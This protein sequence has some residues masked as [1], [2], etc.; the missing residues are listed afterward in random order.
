MKKQLVIIL[1]A[2]FAIGATNT[3]GQCPIPRPVDPVCLPSDAFH[4]VAGTPY[5]YTV[6]VPTPVGTKEYTWLVTQDQNFI[7]AGALVATPQAVPGPIVLAAGP[8]YNDP[9]T[10]SNTINITWNSFVYDPANPI[11]VVIFVRNTASTPDA[12]VTNNM[13]VYRIEPQNS[14]T[15]DIANVTRT[16]VTQLYETPIDR[17]IHDIVSATYNASPEGVIYDFGGDTLFYVVNAANYTTS[18]LPSIQLTGLDPLET[19]TAVEWDYSFAFAAPQAMTL[20]AGTYTSVNPV[21]AQAPGGA[22]GNAGECIWVRVIIDHT[23]GANN[24]QGLAD[25]VISLAVD[26][27]TNIVGPTIGDIHWSS[28]QPVANLLC[29][30]VDGF[31]FDIA[32]QTIKPRPDIQDATPPAGD[33]FLPVQP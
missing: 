25:E 17:C 16:G 26:G 5:A 3:Y 19:V 10:G 1:L 11:F 31:Q 14:F 4:P 6:N 21:L 27:I 33:D 13:K 18:W 24:Y 32:M 23:N 9:A 29:G 28:T 8:G 12:C 22:V 15:L 7:N 30:Q 2:I 20:A